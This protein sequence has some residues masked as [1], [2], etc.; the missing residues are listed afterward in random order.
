MNILVLGGGGREHALAW[1]I[2]QNPKCGR[3]IVAPGNAG[4]AQLADCAALDVLDG[5]AVVAF[6][7]ANAVDFVVIGPEA[8][9]AAGV[10]DALAAAGILAFGPSAAAARLEASKAF[11]KEICDAC[12]APT[13]A[14]ARFTEAGPARDHIR[15]TGAP[16]VVKADGLAAGKGV[17]VAMTEAQ[18]LEGIDEIFGGAFGAAGAEV[19]IEEF[20]TG[21]EAS[22][23]VLCDGETVL[24]IGSAQDHK[25]AFDGD[26]GPN[27]GGMGAYSPAPVLTDAI[28]E[29]ALAQIVRPT[30]AEMARR[31]TPFKGVLYAGLMI[32]KGAARLV[33]YNVR[34]GDPECQVLMMRLGAQVL[35]LLLACAE[36]RL[37]GMQVT[38]AEDHALSVVMAT[39][40][41]P[42]DH[43]RGS[44]IR[45]LEELPETSL[46]MVFH[47]GTAARDGG[48]IASGGRVLNVT[49]R[50][51]SLAE[52]RERAYGLVD[53]IDWPGGFCRR[54]IGWRAL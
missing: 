28:A 36:G 48:I 52:A 30:I 27:T 22:F 17:I 10:A 7:E 49:A 50:G 39:N 31:G 29:A 18:A 20:M 3:L 24:P 41:Y 53:R 1:A 9:L 34:F 38:W 26:T 4:I 2:K 16:I 5:A 6:C 37:A 51:A 21:E 33:E 12:G 19:V 44:Q 32:E 42:G 46:E 35:D 11:T 13:A 23:F 14:Y 45:G 43:A 15:R 8:P 54:D 25:R 47:A 40:G